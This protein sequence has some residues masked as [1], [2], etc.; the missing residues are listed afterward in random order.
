LVKGSKGD[1]MLS[2]H[3]F[4]AQ[5]GRQNGQKLFRCAFAKLRDPV[6]AG[7]SWKNSALPGSGFR[8]ESK[9]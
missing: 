5:K 1:Q 4:M 7:G 8:I 6:V 2:T 3:R 9:R